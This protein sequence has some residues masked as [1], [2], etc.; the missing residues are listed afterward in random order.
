MNFFGLLYLLLAHFVC[1]RGAL[2]LFGIK[3]KMLHLI[4]LSMMIGVAVLSFVPCV[5][6]LM[7]I[8][9]TLFSVLAGIAVFTAVLSIP[10]LA[11][12][13]WPKIKPATSPALYEW[14]FIII[15]FF[16][17]AVSVWRCFYYPPMSGDMLTGPELIAEY[18]VRE[19]T[20]INS[21]FSVDLS[22]TNNYFKSPFI[23]GS[24]IIYKLL[25]SPFGQLWLSV[26]FV[27][28]S[29]WLYSLMRSFLHP[30]IAGFLMLFFVTI[31]DLY[32]YTY[33]ILYD[34]SNTVFFFAGFYFLYNW[35]ID[36][37]GIKGFA[38]SAFLFGIA[39]YIRTE[40]LVLIFMVTPLLAM[41]LY[42]I[43]LQLNKALLLTGLFL[44][45]PVLF[46]VICINVFVHNFVPIP[47]DLGS[48]VNP[49][50]G[51]MSVFFTRLYEM[52]S[53]LI[54][55][56]AGIKEY[57][58]FIFFF[59]GILIID[60][61]WI[62]RFNT[63]AIIALYGIMVVYIGLAFLG[64]LLPPVDLV[65]TT[66]RGLFKALP[67]MLLYLSASGVVQR[68][69]SGIYQWE[70]ANLQEKNDIGNTS[71]HE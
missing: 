59:L 13:K 66:K 36:E 5:L 63:R 48:Q 18:T 38:F 2:Q 31:P 20:M 70:H 24:Q 68:L 12:L 62:R 50:L 61:F 34:Y 58:Y 4:C 28:F 39:T 17:V 30:L 16:L 32:A 11:D 37:G 44:M 53:I 29:I 9:I 43:K 7:H 10:M 14:P 40:T 33:I 52:W 23:T 35:R 22:M 60:I 15:I 47:F 64:Y 56:S 54:C 25:V 6:Q 42:R 26:I 8:T 65:N 67:L 57:G 21:V 41:Y 69:S 55:S 51:D 3:M 46:Y 71:L 45:T 27:S 49:N 19:H 1:G